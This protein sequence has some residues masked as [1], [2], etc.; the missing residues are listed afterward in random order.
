MRVMIGMMSFNV[1]ISVLELANFWLAM[2]IWV[3]TGLL[4]YKQM[5]KR[6]GQP[7]TIEWGLSR[8]N[9]IQ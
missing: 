7:L 1:I 9:M 4:F 6:S 8:K 5:E 2:G 3:I